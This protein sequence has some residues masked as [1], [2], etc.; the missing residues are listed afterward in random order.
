VIR[1]RFLAP[2]RAKGDGFVVDLGDDEAMVVLRLI[3]ELRELLTDPAP[4]GPGLE[5][6]H[7]LFP[8]AHPDDDEAE[9]EYQRLM[10]E[11]LVE[12]KL[13]AIA[14]AE[15]T[16]SGDGR[17]DEDGLVAFMQSINSLR[18]VLGTMLEVT[19]DPD[20]DEVAPQYADGPEYALYGYL[21]Y[22]LDLSTRAIQAG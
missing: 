17:L 9:A 13:A 8:V 21:S 1:R 6:I 5:L 18:L 15:E 20:V 4:D 7:R 2:I 19:D 14:I 22:L 3:A 12:S 10:R 11:E 16:L